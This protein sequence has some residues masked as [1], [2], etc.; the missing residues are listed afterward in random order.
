MGT[1]AAE[2][3]GDVWGPVRRVILGRRPV[4][5]GVGIALVVAAGV[6]AAVAGNGVALGPDLGGGVSASAVL[7]DFAADEQA[8]F[9]AMQNGD[10]S[11]ASGKLTGNTIQ[12]L[13]GQV[14]S[15]QLAGVRQRTQLQQISVAVLREADPND[16]STDIEV[17]QSAYETRIATNPAGAYI[18]QQQVR[19][20]ARFWLRPVDGHWAITDVT[21]TE[22]PGSPPDYTAPA[23]AAGAAILLVAAGGLV[24]RRRRR[25]APALPGAPSVQGAGAATAEGLGLGAAHVLASPPPSPAVP[26]GLPPAWTGAGSAAAAAAGEAVLGIR[27]TG[28]LQVWFNG[29]DLAPLLL[30]SSV[31]GFVWLRLLVEALSGSGVA[32]MTRE[33]MCDEVYVGLDRTTQHSRLR[34]RLHDIKGF[35]KV[36]AS[37]FSADATTVSLDVSAAAVDVLDL[38]TLADT[39]AALPTISAAQAARAD[40]LLGLTRGEVLPSWESLDQRITNGRGSSEEAVRALRHRVLSCRLDLMVALAD[41]HL[42]GGRLER[43]IEVLEEALAARPDREDAAQRLSVAYR[44][45]GRDRAASALASEYGDELAPQ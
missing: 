16:P 45:A 29:T 30:K 33:S 36:L 35:P 8:M 38:F 39:C 43:A 23:G 7:R 37:V 31:S 20:D 21:T 4:A 25:F 26:S 44:A 2:P 10:A 28:T 3:Q 22:T 1:V 24:L 19:F 13:E 40:E 15:E 42:G 6:V 14:S 17:R 34:G 41:H 11:T 27:V 12:E 9:D 32:V 5:I 18:T